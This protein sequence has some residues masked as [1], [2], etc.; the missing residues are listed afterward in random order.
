MH[1]LKAMQAA[2]IN[3]NP[4]NRIRGGRVRSSKRIR[5]SGN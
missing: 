5:K 2:F 4:I 3:L 1:I